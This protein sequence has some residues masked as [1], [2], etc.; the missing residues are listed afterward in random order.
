[1]I[2]NMIEGKPQPVYGDGKN[3]RLLQRLIDIIAQESN[4]PASRIQALITYVKDRPG[5]D[6][7]YAIDCTK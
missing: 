2:L 6:R 5:H 1:M 7:R 3:I 4:K